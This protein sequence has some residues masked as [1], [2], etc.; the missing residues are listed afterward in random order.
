MAA[1]MGSRYWWLKQIDGFWPSNECIIE[2][3]VFDAINAGFSQVVF[4]IRR[5]IEHEFKKKIWNKLEKHIDVI[6]VFQE[7]DVLPE[8]YVSKIQREKP[9]GT[10]H[11]ALCAKDHIHN[12]FACINAD[13]FYGPN[14]FRQ[15]VWFLQGCKQQDNTYALVTYDLGNTLSDHGSVS[16]GICTIGTD[17]YLKNLSEHTNIVRWKQGPYHT[18]EDGRIIELEDTTPA[19]MS[20]FGFTPSFFGILEREF[21]NFLDQNISEPKYEYYL[22]RAVH[23]AMHDDGATVHVI[24]SKDK[25][26]WV[27]NPA[28]KCICQDA[29]SKLVNADVYPTNLWD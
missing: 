12:N 11:A 27:T 14:A 2:Y 24:Q 6:Y 19:S 17:G 7:N 10:G 21:C 3:S 8:G 1:G 20:F 4:V 22:P 9:W 29:I 5:D 26:Y 18:C 28:D 25:W 15:M 16:R 13:D 23:K